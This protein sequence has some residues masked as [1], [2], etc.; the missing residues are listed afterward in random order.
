MDDGK[1]A[2]ILG[3]VAGLPGVGTRTLAGMLDMP[4]SSLDYHLRR[5]HRDG[6]LVC[7][8]RGRSVSWFIAGQGYCPVLRRALPLLRREET[9]HIA[10]LLA[11]TPQSVGS[12]VQ[13]TGYSLGLVR[14]N[15]SLLET[16]GLVERNVPGRAV[17]ARGAETCRERAI[18]Q[19][20]C[21]QWGACAISRGLTSCPSPSATGS[22]RDRSTGP[23]RVPSAG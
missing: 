8:A 22:G 14:W 20:R 7:D 16:A 5:L 11:D 23:P 18:A 12:L 9:H 13:E 4:E 6:Q 10:L 2:L 21:D 15:L 3:R 1:R 17:L 19:E